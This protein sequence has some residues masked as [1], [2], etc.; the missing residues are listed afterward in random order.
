MSNGTNNGKLNLD[1]ILKIS[2][3]LVIPLIGVMLWFLI[4]VGKLDT[5]ISI[6]ESFA[7]SNPNVLSELAIIRDRQ[8]DVRAKLRIIETEF[9]RHQIFSTY[10]PES[11]RNGNG[12]SRITK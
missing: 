3:I 12:Q 8:D 6:I 4:M 11:P 9:H 10:D 2:Q 5:R 1:L 7:I